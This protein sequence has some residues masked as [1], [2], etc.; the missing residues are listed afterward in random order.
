MSA[1]SCLAYHSMPLFIDPLLNYSK[2]VN[3]NIKK[4]L[5][6]YNMSDILPKVHW[7]LPKFISLLKKLSGS[8][9]SLNHIPLA[10]ILVR[11]SVLLLSKRAAVLFDRPLKLFELRLYFVTNFRFCILSISKTILKLNEFIDSVKVE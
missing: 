4:V 7:F 5:L 11:F 2:K 9:K 8:P 6:F 1:V 10:F 3:I